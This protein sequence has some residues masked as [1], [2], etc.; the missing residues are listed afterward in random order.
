MFPKMAQLKAESTIK[1]NTTQ[2]Y[3]LQLE[4]FQECLLRLEL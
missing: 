3:S 4:A 1:D 2:S